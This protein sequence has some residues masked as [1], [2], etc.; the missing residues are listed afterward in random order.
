[1]VYVGFSAPRRKT[2]INFNITENAPSI[3]KMHSWVLYSK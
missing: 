2:R 1:M 3:K